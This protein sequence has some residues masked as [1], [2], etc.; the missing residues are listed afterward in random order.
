[1]DQKKIFTEKRGTTMR[2]GI[3][4]ELIVDIEQKQKQKATRIG[5]G[6]RNG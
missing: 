1:M 4:V 6:F 3:G 2:H 5:E